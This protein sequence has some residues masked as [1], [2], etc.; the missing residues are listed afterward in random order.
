MSRKSPELAERHIE[1]YNQLASQVEQLEDRLYRAR[2][3]KETAR[4]ACFNALPEGYGIVM[5]ERFQL[6]CWLDKRS[7][8]S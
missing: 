4:A 5:G 3:A 6:S 2:Q 1:R 8:E 7:D